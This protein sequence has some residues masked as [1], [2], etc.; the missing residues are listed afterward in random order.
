MDVSVTKA[1]V[2]CCLLS[3][4]HHSMSL[5]Q[6]S[7]CCRASLHPEMADLSLAAGDTAQHRNVLCT[8]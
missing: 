3:A 2:P 6:L 5:L 8:G 7:A 4:A 1:A